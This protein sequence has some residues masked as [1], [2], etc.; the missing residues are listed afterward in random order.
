MRE[1]CT[2][3]SEG[4]VTFK[5]SSLPLSKTLARLFMHVCSWDFV[6]CPWTFSPRERGEN[7]PDDFSRIEPTQHNKAPEDA[8]V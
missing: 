3:S 4:G 8:S 5:P 2:Y 6:I 1:N 7:S